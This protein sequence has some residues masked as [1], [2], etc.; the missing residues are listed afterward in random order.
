MGKQNTH[1]VPTGLCRETIGVAS[2]V[3]T[4]SN[5]GERRRRSTVQ[6]RVQESQGGLTRANKT[7]IDQRD[8]T[9]EDRGRATCSGDETSLLLEDDLDVVTHGSDVGE[10]SS[11][12]VELA[13]VGVAEFS[14]VCGYGGGLV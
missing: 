8:N 13:R 12:G 2:G 1:W 10:G 3:V 5:I 7:V 9:S 4:G 6:E 14:E 11:A